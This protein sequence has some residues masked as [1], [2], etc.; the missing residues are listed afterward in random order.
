M[1][2]KVLDQPAARITALQYLSYAVTKTYFLLSRSTIVAHNT[3]TVAPDRRY[4]LASTHVSWFDPFLATTALGWRHL[5]PLLPCR[6][7]ATPYFLKKR[8]LRTA[9]LWLGAYPSHPFRDM[10]FGLDAS[11]RLLDKHHTIV[12]FPQGK[13]NSVDSK[14]HRGVAELANHPDTLVIPVLIHK[15]GHFL[16]MPSFLIYVGEPFDAAGQSAE[17]IMAQVFEMGEPLPRPSV[18]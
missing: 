8:L 14:V 13:R 9:M 5:R 6:F 12:I 17:A 4:V 16:G 1:T 11:M 3:W 2:E 18:A 15:K 10:A 7:I